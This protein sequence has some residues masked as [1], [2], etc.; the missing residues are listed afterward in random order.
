MGRRTLSFLILVAALA[1]VALWSRERS[2]D[3]E[4]VD[5]AGV[6]AMP[7][8][9]NAVLVLPV[10]ERERVPTEHAPAP[11]TE[12]ASGGVPKTIDAVDAV[13]EDGLVLE[14]VDE[15]LAPAAGVDIWY[16]VG[17]AEGHARSRALRELL[18]RSST[19]ADARSGS[20]GRV[21]IAV[22]RSPRVIHASRPSTCA[23]CCTSFDSI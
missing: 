22:P 15:S 14:V 13:E 23:G 3:R 17:A 19:S 5:S 1:V 21:R 16:H 12:A 2:L 7:E 8:A 10:D 6:V 20:D 4:R 11:A 9:R 18:E